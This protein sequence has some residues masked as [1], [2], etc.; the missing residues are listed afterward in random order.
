MKR[1]DQLTFIRF[2]MVFMIVLYHGY[3]GI[4]TEFLMKIP[5]WDALLGTATTAVGY[6]YVLSGFV[7]SLV[8]Y[9]PSEKFDIAAYWKNRFIRIY[10]LYIFAF[11]LTCVYYID[12]I[13][14]VKPQKILANIFVLQ[15]WFPAY[16]QS[17]NY[18]AWSITVEIFFYLIF[19]FFTLWAYR[20]SIK[21]LIWGSIGFWAVSQLIYHILWIGYFS[22]HSHF[23][24]YFPIFHLNSFIMGVVGGIWYVQEGGHRKTSKAINAFLLLLSSILSIGYL[25]ASMKYFPA[26]PRELQPMAGIIAPLMVLFI[27]SLALDESGLSKFLSHPWLV[28]LGEASYA[29]YILHVPLAWFCEKYLSSLLTLQTTGLFFSVF[30]VPFLVAISLVIYKYVDEPIRIWLRKNIPD[31]NLTLFFFDLLLACVSVYVAFYLRFGEGRDFES[32]RL[33][34]RLLFWSAFFLRMIL[35][36]GFRTIYSK[37]LRS[38]YFELSRLVLLSSIFGSFVLFVIG[39]LGF[40]FGLY[41]N[42]P[43]SVLIVDF[44]IF[45]GGS[46]VSRLV[47]HKWIVNSSKSTAVAI[48]N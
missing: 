4:Y 42:F 9:R 16:S 32:Y 17:F 12:S 24:L 39:Y 15:S 40:K 19:P 45:F 46:L 3:G 37:I 38:S 34:I 11:L 13:L 14:K 26:M 41:E 21:K 47:F 43:R 33:M 5:F 35:S 48:Q 27:I 18:P 23:L 25:I 30:F 6:M 7:M 36:L 29:I 31:I 20:Q 28:N 1:L 8:Y 44:M 22:T 10:P 2:C